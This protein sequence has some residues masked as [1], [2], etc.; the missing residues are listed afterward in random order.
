TNQV[1]LAWSAPPGGAGSYNV[2][3]G[4]ATGVTRFAG[5]DAGST[6]STT[7]TNTGLSS[8]TPYFFVVTA[9]NDA[10]ESAESFE[11]TATPTAPGAPGTLDTTFN[12]V[13]FATHHDAGGAGTAEKAWGVAISDAGRIYAAGEAQ[14]VLG[15]LDAIVWAF[16]PDGGLDPSFGGGA[17]FVSSRSAAGANGTDIAYGL[18]VDSTGRIVV[19]GASYNTSNNY[20]IVI[21]RYDANG[22]LDNTFGSA[23]T[24]IYNSGLAGAASHDYAYI[25]A[26]DP[27]GRI[28]VV[29]R[30]YGGAAASFDGVILRLT[31]GGVL[32]PTFGTGGAAFYKGAGDSW[33]QMLDLEFTSGG[34]MIVVGYSQPSAG[35]SDATL[36]KVLPDGGLDSTFGSAG[37][38]KHPG[39]AASAFTIPRGLAIDGMGRIVMSGFSQVSPSPQV[40]MVW[41]VTAGGVLDTTFND[42]GFAA[43][44]GVG[45]GNADFFKLRIDS[46]GRYVVS[47]YGQNGTTRDMAVVRYLPDGGFDPTFG[48]GGVL[49]HNSAAGGGAVDEGWGLAL[50]SVGRIVVVGKSWAGGFNDYDMAIWRVNP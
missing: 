9:V 15:N 16:L 29:G 41:R 39:L 35:R 14:G 37:V 10:G 20:D 3:R 42:A 11:V 50:D 32:D 49:F 34:E 46:S 23:G 21:W 7:F 8:G 26:I 28:V 2:Y 24:F 36:W 31:D 12:G 6:T 45:S 43:W 38:F 40:A 5:A 4:T 19:V 22:T 33:D 17:G 30:S 27:A 48:S 25:P 18:T 13:G 44:T 1:A 47:G